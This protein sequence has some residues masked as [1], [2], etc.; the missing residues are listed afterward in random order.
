VNCETQEALDYYWERLAKGG[1][2]EQC[3]WLKDKF[4]VSW[5]I[6]PKA[7]GE[8]LSAADPEKSNRVMQAIMKMVKLDIQAIRQAYNGE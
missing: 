7:L 8:M 6:N 1:V 5:Q 4:G 3:G 2:L